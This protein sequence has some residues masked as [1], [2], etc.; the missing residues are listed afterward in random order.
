MNKII[1]KLKAMIES[2]DTRV[3]LKNEISFIDKDPLIDLHVNLEVSSLL[4]SNTRKKSDLELVHEY[5]LVKPKTNLKGKKNFEK[6]NAILIKEIE[7]NNEIDD[8]I[9]PVVR[10]ILNA[11][12]PWKGFINKEKLLSHLSYYFQDRPTTVKTILKIVKQ[13]HFY[14]KSKKVNKQELFDIVN[15]YTDLSSIDDVYKDFDN[16]FTRLDAENLKNDFIDN[17]SI[18]SPDIAKYKV[19]FKFEDWYEDVTIEPAWMVEEEMKYRARS[20]VTRFILLILR[21]IARY[22]S[23][24]FQDLESIKLIWDNDFK[25]YEREKTKVN[26]KKLDNDIKNQLLFWNVDIFLD[27]MDLEDDPELEEMLE[28]IFKH[29]ILKQNTVLDLFKSLTIDK[30]LLKLIF[31]WS[32]TQKRKIR[33]IHYELKNYIK[34]E[35]WYNLQFDFEK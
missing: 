26:W 13:Y 30:N 3:I 18:I 7:K 29:L 12:I 22:N 32:R 27:N 33:F 23:Q 17:L 11:S 15:F 6:L 24:I 10:I 2:V 8:L 28:Y 35:Y 4:A 25:D 31:W 5:D 34:E 19:V 1:F 21:D 20:E 9:S 14:A 16:F